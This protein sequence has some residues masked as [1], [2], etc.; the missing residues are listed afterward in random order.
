MF[1]EIPLKME[2]YKLGRNIQPRISR[3]ARTASQ[4]RPLFVERLGNKSSSS[5]PRLMVV[6]RSARAWATSLRFVN[7]LNEM[8]LLW[9][10]GAFTGMGGGTACLPEA[11]LVLQ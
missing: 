6:E 4:T 3:T 5:N 8:S 2:E 9:M 10:M 1:A 11:Q 7:E